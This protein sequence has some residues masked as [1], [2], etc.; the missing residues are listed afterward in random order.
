MDGKS[1]K[2]PIHLMGC[3]THDFDHFLSWMY[4]ALFVF[5]FPGIGDSLNVG[6]E[7]YRSTAKGY[8]KT[9]RYDDTEISGLLHLDID[10]GGQMA[11]G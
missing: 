9:E 8:F 3:K 11:D 2:N 6:Q 1:N 4:P 7:S 10:A 5:L